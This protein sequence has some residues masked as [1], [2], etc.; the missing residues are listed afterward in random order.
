M[1]EYSANLDE[2]PTADSPFG[3]VC[4]ICGAPL[5]C[6][7][8]YQIDDDGAVTAFHTECKQAAA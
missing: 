8:F 2:P 4:S 6:V 7:F 3:A 5:G 1:P